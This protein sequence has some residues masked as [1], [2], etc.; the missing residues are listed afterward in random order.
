MVGGIQ[1][2]LEAVSG[3]CLVSCYLLSFVILPSSLD[4]HVFVPFSVYANYVLGKNLE[5]IHF[6]YNLGMCESG[7]VLRVGIK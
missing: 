7:S 2:W 6:L 1:N 3:C 5:L 4:L